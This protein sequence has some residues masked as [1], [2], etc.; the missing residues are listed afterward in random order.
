MFESL[1]FFFIYELQNFL[2]APRMLVIVSIPDNIDDIHSQSVYI[3]G[4]TVGS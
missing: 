3:V 1:W 4:E 2:N